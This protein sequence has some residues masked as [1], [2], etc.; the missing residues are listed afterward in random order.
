MSAKDGRILLRADGVGAADAAAPSMAPIFA[1][2]RPRAR[3]NTHVDANARRG[4]EVSMSRRRLSNM[5]GQS[6]A[7][8]DGRAVD[9]ISMQTGRDTLSA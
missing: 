2:G 7:H 5:R 4:G 8:A 9:F 3:R 6:V 1:I